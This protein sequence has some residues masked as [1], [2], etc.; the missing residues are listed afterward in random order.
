[1]TKL[2]TI[3]LSMAVA[4]ALVPV[5]AGCG[6]KQTDPEAEMNRKLQQIVAA[7][8]AT[9]VPTKSNLTPVLA[10][11]I[12][13]E[14]SVQSMAEFPKTQD[15]PKDPKDLAALN[16]R[17]RQKNDQIYAK[18]GTTMGETMR[19][20]SDLSPKDREAYNEKLTQLFLEHSKKNVPA[21]VPGTP[22]PTMPP[23]LN[24]PMPEKQA[25]K[26]APKKKQ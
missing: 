12:T 26:P 23:E 11:Q 13:H 9:K 16:E 18:F 3:S 19:F 22:A 10:A 20:I 2:K 6:K 7:M 5:L 17:I 24:N 1:M 21:E 25:V 8:Q 4:M 14:I 15:L